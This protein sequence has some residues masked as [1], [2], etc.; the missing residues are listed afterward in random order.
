MLLRY[1]G[2]GVEV[3]GGRVGFSLDWEL[4]ALKSIKRPINNG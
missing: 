2:L 3:G 1:V 4:F